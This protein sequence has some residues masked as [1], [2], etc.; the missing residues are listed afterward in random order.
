MGQVGQVGQVAVSWLVV[1]ENSPAWLGPVLLGLGLVAWTGAGTMVH[2]GAPEPPTVKTADV[3]Q[4]ETEETEEDPI[5]IVEDGDEGPL[6]TPRASSSSSFAATPSAATEEVACAPSVE[7]MFA[8][9]ESDVDRAD[10]LHGFE[11]TAK[12]FPDHK[13]VIEGYASVDGSASGNMQLSHRRASRAEARL[14]KQ[15]ISAER[16]TVQ[17]F[18][19]YRP[20]LVGDVE[21]DRRVVVKIDGIETCPKRGAEE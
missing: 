4:P 11:A 5:V 13:I 10:L 18:G 12:A 16:I 1:G 15:G 21:R 3:A 20:N 7:F 9:G 19:E 6:P 2:A 17:A 8:N 14:V